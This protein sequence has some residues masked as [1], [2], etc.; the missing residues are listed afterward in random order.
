MCSE[1]AG[2][3][4]SADPEISPIYM[5]CEGLP[6]L[7]FVASSNEILMDDTVYLARRTAAAGNDTT[8][9]IWPLLPHAFPLFG[10]YFPEAVEA[11]NDM[12]AFMQKHLAR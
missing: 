5:D 1:Y 12:A 8:C 7:F 9:H 3:Q 2:D 10:G 6:P 4:D 11:R